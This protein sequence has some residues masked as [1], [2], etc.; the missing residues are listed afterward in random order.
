MSGLFLPRGCWVTV[1]LQNTGDGLQDNGKCRITARGSGE[2]QCMGLVTVQ[3]CCIK[4]SRQ[5]L[6]VHARTRAHTHTS[7][8]DDGSRVQPS[9][10]MWKSFEIPYQLTDSTLPWSKKQE[11]AASYRRCSGSSGVPEPVGDAGHS[12][13][14]S[15]LFLGDA[16]APGD[17]CWPGVG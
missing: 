16:P 11:K 12:W 15:T 17:P 4:R 1:L 5:G 10:R 7:D 13:D 9:R 8:N 14:S 6:Q 3:S 2:K